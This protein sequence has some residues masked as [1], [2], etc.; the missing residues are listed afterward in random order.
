LNWG[1]VGGVT[2]LNLHLRSHET[3]VFE[4]SAPGATATHSLACVVSALRKRRNRP[5]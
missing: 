3:T 5:W 2:E 1:I 4:V